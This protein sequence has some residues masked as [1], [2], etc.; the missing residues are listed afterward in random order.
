M[1]RVACLERIRLHGFVFVNIN[2][3]LKNSPASL[4]VIH[5]EGFC[6]MQR[7]LKR[8]ICNIIDSGDF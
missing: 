4:C 1:Y 3:G 2:I 6:E 8:R 7:Y 5:I